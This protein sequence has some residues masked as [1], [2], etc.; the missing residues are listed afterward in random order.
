MQLFYIARRFGVFLLIVWLAATLNFFLPK[1]SGEDPVRTKLLEQAS[2]GGYVQGGIEDMVKEYQEKFGLDKP[3]WRQYLAYVGDMVRGDLNYSIAN[4]PRTV[5]GMIADALPWTIGLLGLTTLFSFVAGTILGALL[6]WPGA[7]RWMRWLMPPLWALHAIPFFLLGL[8]LMYLLAFQFQLLPIFGGYSA[9]ATP[10]WTWRFVLDVLRHATL[11]ALSIILVSLGGW[12]L[13]MRGMMVTTMGEDY[14]TFAEAK[15]LR[16]VTIFTRYCMRNAILP[17]ATGLAL[18]LG[19]ILSG[20]VLVEA[21][22]GYPGIG[23]L[24][25]QAIEENDF[26]LIQG[27]VF[28]VI[29]ALGFATFVL[30]VI[31][32]LLDPR[33][34][35]RRS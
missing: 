30:D 19:Q 2:L 10:A 28:T 5:A 14:V 1:L 29:V 8:V 31:Y 23:A 33:I 25:F 13:A 24:L 6:A 12:A 34:S 4:Y 32:P 26:F 17:Q 22:F 18:A 7:P 16:S 9:G 15:G 21:I 11:P 35:Y 3:L 27:I 20:A